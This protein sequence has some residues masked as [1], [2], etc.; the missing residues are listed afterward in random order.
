M[1]TNVDILFLYW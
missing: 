1:D